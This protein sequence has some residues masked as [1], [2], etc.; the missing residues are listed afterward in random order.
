[1]GPRTWRATLHLRYEREVAE[2]LA[3]PA[4]VRQGALIPTAHVLGGGFRPA[5]R[6]PLEDVLHVDRW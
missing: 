2:L 1:M 4:G 5:R 3:L 6:R